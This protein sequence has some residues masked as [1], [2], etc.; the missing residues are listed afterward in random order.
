MKKLVLF[1]MVLILLTGCKNK[2]ENEK[3]DYLT[4]KSNLLEKKKFTNNNDIPCDITIDVNRLNKEQISYKVT[5]TN[6]KED[7]NDI[8]M[9]IVHNY[10]TE[11]AF[12]SIGFFNKKKEL[13][14][15]T[16]TNI[17]IKEKIETTDDIDKLNLEF[18]IFIQYKTNDNQTK[19]IYYKTT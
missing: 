17:T 19:E 3:N 15:N 1:I 7:M 18:K 10:Y 14:T 12:P 4:M 9:I 6:P 5:L 13:K 16:D 2:E 8:K 11:D